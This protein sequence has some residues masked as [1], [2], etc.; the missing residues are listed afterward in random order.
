MGLFPQPWLLQSPRPLDLE[1]SLILGPQLGSTLCWVPESRSLLHW[2]TD[3]EF[4]NS[5]PAQLSRCV[6]VGLPA[7]ATPILI[8][9]TVLPSF[10]EWLFLYIPSL[11]SLSV[12]KLYFVN[13]WSSSVAILCPTLCWN[14]VISPKLLI[15]FSNERRKVWLHVLAARKMN[16]N[17]VMGAVLLKESKFGQFWAKSIIGNPGNFFHLE[18][19][20]SR[21][22][23][24]HIWQQ[25]EKERVVQSPNYAKLPNQILITY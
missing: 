9:D 25:S 22:C 8:W 11:I 20:G 16:K 19:F 13:K 12:C 4:H 24:K 5:V 10:N 3:G 6:S 18:K 7:L 17:Q 1:H 21:K 15:C 23:F 14:Q 2:H